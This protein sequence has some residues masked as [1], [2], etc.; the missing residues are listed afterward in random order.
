[1]N[2]SIYKATEVSSSRHLGKGVNENIQIG[3][4]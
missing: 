2:N 4:C 1:M 3:E